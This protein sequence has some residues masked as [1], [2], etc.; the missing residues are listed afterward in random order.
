MK[1]KVLTALA[2]AMCILLA[3]VPST[4]SDPELPLAKF[5]RQKLEHSQKVLEGLSRENYDMISSNAEA[6]NVLGQATSWRVLQTPEYVQYSSE[7]LRLTKK[8]DEMAAD[9]NLDGAT[10]T[11]VQLTVNCVNCHKHVRQVRAASVD[12]PAP[13]F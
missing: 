6:L 3:G 11:Y 2:T 12:S 7:F 5:M 9:K 4:R 1:V 13:R 10:L 8:L